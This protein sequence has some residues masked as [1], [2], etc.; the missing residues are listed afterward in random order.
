MIREGAILLRVQNLQ[1]R[2]GRIAV[3]I[4]NKLVH[5]VQNHNRIL[6]SGP[7]HALHD[8]AGHGADIGSAVSAN[9]CFV[10]HTAQTDADILTSQRPCDALPDAGLAGTGSAHE[11]QDRAGLLPIQ[12]H[13]CQL[14]DDSLLHLLQAVVILI[15]NLLRL[16]KIHILHGFR[17]PGKRS[18]KVQ[19]VI[20]HA[21]LMA[22]LA[23]LLH[24]V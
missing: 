23:L 21:V 3:V 11:E 17:L 15:Q 4:A 12:L 19:I 22:V 13:N 7:L 24:A 18:H 16:H 10:T 9:L 2:A 5:L 20:E 6:R 14:L 8:P 1:Q